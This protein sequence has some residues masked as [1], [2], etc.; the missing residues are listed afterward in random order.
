MRVRNDAGCVDRLGPNSYCH[1]WFHQRLR[2]ADE[3]LKEMIKHDHS[4]NYLRDFCVGWKQETFLSRTSMP[5]CHGPYQ[6]VSPFPSE[7]WFCIELKY[8]IFE[9][10][11]AKAS[12]VFPHNERRLFSDHDD[13]TC[14]R[15]FHETGYEM[16]K[17]LVERNVREYR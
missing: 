2:N 1:L 10:I 15:R 13:S 5:K 7:N 12:T 14:W 4:C 6:K 16:G 9:I 17:K 3:Y 11:Y 8:L